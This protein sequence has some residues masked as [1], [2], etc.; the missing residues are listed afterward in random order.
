MKK[1]FDVLDM[2]IALGIGAI[3]AL[4]IASVMFSL[5]APRI[6]IILV[7]ALLAVVLTALAGY[8]IGW[9]RAKTESLI[10]YNKGIAKGRALGRAEARGDIRHYIEHN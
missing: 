10:A 8:V 7:L 2:L 1:I 4:T 5:G 3:L 9:R 6:I